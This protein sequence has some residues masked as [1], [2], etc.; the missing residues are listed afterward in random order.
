MITD[1]VDPA[2][3]TATP[4]MVPTMRNE[5]SAAVATALPL[6]CITFG[7]HLIKAKWGPDIDPQT[8]LLATIDY[9]DATHPGQNGVHQ[10][11]VTYSRTLVQALLNNYQQVG[12]GRFG[13]T[14]FGLYVPPDIGPTIN[15][16]EAG[17]GNSPDYYHSYEGVYRSTQPQIYAPSTQLP[18][19]AADFKKWVWELELKT[20]YQTYLDQAWPSDETA[21]A[22]EPYALRT[23]VKAVFLMSAWLQHKENSLSPEGLALALQGAGL[24]ISQTWDGL[25]LGQLQ[26]PTPAPET[27]EVSRLTIYRYTA[28]DIWC[29]R[30]RSGSRLLLY[31]PG[32]SSPLHVF[33]DA[34]QLNQWIAVQGRVREMREA[35]AAHFAEEDREDGTFHAGVLTALEAIGLYPAKHS[36]KKDAGLFNDDG[37]WN[38]DDYVGLQPAPARCDLFAQSVLTMKQ[39]A[40]ASVNTIRDDAQV[41]RDALSAVV[42]PV[43]QWINRFGPLALFIPGGEG[44]LALAGLIDAGYGLNE[45]VNADTSQKRSE[46]VSRSVFGLLNALPLFAGVASLQGERRAVETVRELEAAPASPEVG[47]AKLPV[48]SPSESVALTQVTRLREVGES[49]AGLSDEVLQ[50]IVQVCGIDDEV[51]KLIRT[52]GKAPPLLSDTI[53][54][55]RLEHALDPKL[56]PATRAALFNR[57]YQVLQHSENPWVRLLQTQYSGLP[58]NVIEQL[59]ERSAIDTRSTVETIEARQLISALESKAH[60]Y[61]QHLRIDRAYEGLYL[62]S[63]DNPETDHLALHSLERLPGWPASLRIEILEGSISGRVLD[64]I[65]SPE[66]SDCRRLIKVDRHYRAASAEVSAQSDLYHCLLSVLTE[67]EGLALGF[68]SADKLAELRLR[69]GE[70]ALPRAAF[71]RGLD[72]LDS[73][74]SFEAHRGLRGGGFPTTADGA[75]LSHQVMQLQVKSFYPEFTDAQASEWL[76]AL[77]QGAQP[78]LDDLHLEFE[79]LQIDLSHWVDQTATDLDDMDL[80]TLNVGDAGTD[81]MSF[82]QLAAYNEERLR[83]VMDYERE[84][85]NELA[86]ELIAIWRKHP[87]QASRIYEGET[88]TGFRLDLDFED[89]HR[90]PIMNIRFEEVHELSMRSLQVLNRES[91]Q[92]FLESFPNLHSLNLESVDLRQFNDDD[93]LVGM[94]SPAIMK[95]RRLTRLNLKSTFLEFKENTASRL[96]ELDKLQY[97]DL[98]DNPLVVAPVVSGMD[99]LRVLNLK[100]TRITRCPL[101]IAEQ[102]YLTLLDLSDNHIERVPGNVFNQAITRNRLR[103]WNNPLRDED[104]L[105]RLVEHRKRTG[106]N[107][108]LS[109]PDAGYGSVDPWLEEGDEALKQA[110]KTLWSR[111]QAKPSGAVLI[112]MIGGLSMT[113]DA[114][115]D[116]L[117]LQARVWHLL[118]EADASEELWGWLRMC[119]DLAMGDAENPFVLFG[120]LEDRARLYRDWVKLGRPIP[121]RPIIGL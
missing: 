119:V 45:A 106:L 80:D 55:F 108:W 96:C 59:L 89:Y 109:E 120:A 69:L 64:G 67:E 78:R 115:V 58:K 23:A 79:Q 17:T 83:S 63:V 117:N 42:E 49:V 91:L 56:G 92:G 87:S 7:S 3:P 46:G 75:A 47:L 72:R 104:T 68:T 102:P 54:R 74:L 57:Q 86:E 32:N 48:E 40:M 22:A 116:Y 73:G 24:S 38:P 8:T 11:H 107:L 5:L 39:A 52:Q 118:H 36:L 114:Q 20:Q 2:T 19:R 26:A 35:L 81:G 110:R 4:S 84:T 113:A 70:H 88:V 112:R 10:G 14:V 16:V 103:L 82:A 66:A 77:G 121:I 90:L 13:E 9:D 1:L 6:T 43:V 62:R 30:E 28:R 85:R 44:V 37:Y 60:R 50:Q 27:V 101:G 99:E 53:S 95:M 105:R 25:T 100:N 12:D 65:G 29:V 61:Q 98:S 31:M 33:D 18:I 34:R 111:V 21:L 97:L 93:V 41:N 94:L 15:I 76:E 51:L 71:E